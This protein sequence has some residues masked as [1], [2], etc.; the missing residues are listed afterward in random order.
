MTVS[1]LAEMAD[2]STS[3]I[4]QLE[5]G[6]KLPTERL[7]RRLSGVLDVSPRALL[8]AANFTLPLPLTETLRPPEATVDLDEGIS[9]EERE[10][11]LEY[12]S[13]LRYRSGM[14]RGAIIHLTWGAG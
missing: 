6:K 11:L 7:I 14:S 2:L 9:A 13:F 8:K 4:S 10:A 1:R 3:Y 12:L 5:T